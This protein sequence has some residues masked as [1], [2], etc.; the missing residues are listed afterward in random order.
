LPLTISTL[1]ELLQSHTPHEVAAPDA[2]KAGV[3]M[4]LVPVPN[5]F[6]MV[7]MKRSQREGDPWSGQISLPGGHHQPEDND[8]CETARR[9]TLEE[10]GL[11]LEGNPLGQLD[12]V[13]PRTRL[14]PQVL[15]R[16]FV[17]VV[18]PVQQ[19]S[20][21]CE[22][23]IDIRVRIGDIAMS[24]RVRTVAAQG[25]LLK[26]AGY[27]VGSNFVWGLTERVITNFLGIVATAL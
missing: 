9:E 18:E 21:G 4:V 14:I 1:T 2:K 15:V 8:L 17:F 7:L 3:A 13:H 5:D 27:D 16:P 23:E 26:V 22:A 24:R 11:E 10:M 20:L 25:R 12:D 19:L 6:E